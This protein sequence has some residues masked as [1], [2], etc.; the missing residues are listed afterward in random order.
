MFLTSLSKS[1]FP[2]LCAILW[3]RATFFI[4]VTV[5]VPVFGIAVG[6]QSQTV[7]KLATITPDNSP[8]NDTLYAGVEKIEKQ[9]GGRV[10]IRI[11]GNGLAGEET[12]VLRKI[13]LGSVDAGVFTAVALKSVVPKTLVLS[14]PYFV[15]T[16]EDLQMI[17]DELTPGFNK[18]FAKQG[19]E[20]LGWAFSGWI[21]MFYKDDIRSPN[22]VGNVRLGVSPSEPELQAAWQ[23]LNF[24]VTTVTFSDTFISLQNGLLSG[25]YSTPI[26]A[27]A[28]QWFAFT[29]HM[30]DS[31]VAPLLGA[32]L[33][34]SRSWRRISAADRAVIR[35]EMQKMISNF[36]DVA[37]KQD[38][39]AVEVMKKKGLKVY[40]P[41]EAAE[42]AWQDAFHEKGYPQV[43]G[44]NR[45]ISD[46]LYQRARQIIQTR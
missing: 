31:K 3:N 21:Y 10:R 40:A 45:A 2:N 35:S 37:Q 25:F 16:K 20:V 9:T 26:G 27:L 17:M 29:P 23:A 7:L 13:R 12:E 32:V 15:R 5:L 28:Y 22:D 41:T 14:L 43:I 33:V 24:R 19:Y 11:Y 18:D 34:S 39:K 38:I 30:I 46:D 36:S 1:Y 4:I 6:L 8:W 42:Q 44:S